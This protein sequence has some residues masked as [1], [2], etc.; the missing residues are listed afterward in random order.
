ML[1]DVGMLLACGIIKRAMCVVVIVGFSTASLQSRASVAHMCLI[2]KR[3]T[4][5]K[6]GGYCASFRIF[7][8]ANRGRACY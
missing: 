7:L 8:I 1:N 6:P 2:A 3:M 5:T 4:A